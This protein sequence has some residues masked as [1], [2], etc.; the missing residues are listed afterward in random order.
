MLSSELPPKLPEEA[1]LWPGW[2]VA[3]C[4]MYSPVVITWCSMWDLW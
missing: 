3:L 4:S 2:W 1:T